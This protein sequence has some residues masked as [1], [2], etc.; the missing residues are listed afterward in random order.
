[1]KRSGVSTGCEQKAALVF[2]MAEAGVDTGGIGGAMKSFPSCVCVC[3][4][5]F[6]PFACI[7]PEKTVPVDQADIA[8]A[9]TAGSE[10]ARAGE[11]VW[12]QRAASSSLPRPDSQL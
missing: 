4:R 1:M 6:T 10:G 3:V 11:H 5:V 2:I 12:P 9:D 7:C 8:G